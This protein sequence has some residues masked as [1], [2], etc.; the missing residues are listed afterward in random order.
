MFVL[1][2]AAPGELDGRHLKARRLFLGLDEAVARQLPVRAR[3]S[4][5]CATG[6]ARAKSPVWTARSYTRRAGTAG[7]CAAQSVTESACVQVSDRAPARRLQKT[8]QLLHPGRRSPLIA[9]GARVKPKLFVDGCAQG[10]DR[11]LVGFRGHFD[12]CLWTYRDGVRSHLTADWRSCKAKAVVFLCARQPQASSPAL[13]NP[14]PLPGSECPPRRLAVG[15][16]YSGAVAVHLARIADP[17]SSVAHSRTC[18]GDQRACVLHPGYGHGECAA[19][20]VTWPVGGDDAAAV[21]WREMGTLAMLTAQER[22]VMPLTC[23]T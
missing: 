22:I 14:D 11:A 4:S 5:G 20:T 1:A 15:T 13:R 16:G 21:E 7:S 8:L 2:G 3:T 12:S 23:A 19:R 6:K 18:R 9:I 17:A 10:S